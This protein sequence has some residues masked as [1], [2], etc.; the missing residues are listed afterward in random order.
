MPEENDRNIRIPVKEEEGKH[1]DHRVRTIVL[2]AKE[3]VKALYCTECKS[4]ITYIFAKNK[5][6]TMDKA[7][8][9][10]QEH[11]KSLIDLR[12][13]HVDQEAEF[14]KVLGIMRDEAPTETYF[15]SSPSFILNK[16]IY[17]STVGI[18]E[19]DKARGQG[20]GVGGERQGDGG[21]DMCLCPKCGYEIPHEKGTPCKELTCPKCGAT[22]VGKEKSL[23]QQIDIVKAD[24]M[25]RLV[26]GVFL[27][28]DKADHDG[29]V[30]SP[31][32]I[33]KVAHKF[34]V[35]Y[36]TIDEMHK[37]VV[38]ASIV[39][40]AI[41]WEDEMDFHGKKLSKGT[42][43]GAIKINDEKV[44]GNVLSGK[45][46]AFSVRISGVREPIKENQ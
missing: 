15:P 2:S 7:K 18:S 10:M 28:P 27:V 8:D 37:N 13:V 4:I 41:A 11:K 6:W 45:Y 23:D 16:D 33:E 25:K 12:E 42:W 46:K 43:F 17:E 5:G 34:V 40:S 1:S 38:E 19:E 26:Y 20:Q 9:W 44:W 36:R 21:A 14:M 32:D 24:K 39:E 31:E 35:D 29:D 22:L 3:G 30:I